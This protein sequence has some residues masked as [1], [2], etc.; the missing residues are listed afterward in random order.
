M[1]A[2]VGSC[3]QAFENSLIKAF[4]TVHSVYHYNNYS[5]YESLM[6]TLIT[7]NDCSTYHTCTNEYIYLHIYLIALIC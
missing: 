1:P 2:I 7:N 4:L 5:H 6:R 3:C